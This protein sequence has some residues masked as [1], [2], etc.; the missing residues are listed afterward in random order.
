MMIFFFWFLKCIPCVLIALLGRV[1]MTRSAFYHL[2]LVGRMVNCRLLREGYAH[3]CWV[4][5]HEPGISSLILVLV[6]LVPS[7]VEHTLG[8]NVL[9]FEVRIFRS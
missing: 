2:P 6:R 4:Y 1:D 5:T 3:G 9:S 7:S 8:H